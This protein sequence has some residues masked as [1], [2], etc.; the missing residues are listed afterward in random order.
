MSKI[1]AP[2]G[3]HDIFSPEIEKWQYLEDSIRRFFSCYLFT[4][5]RT[6]LF[7]HSELFLRG[8]GNE[9]EV[10]Q[11]EM[12]TFMDKGNRSITLR[13]E[14][15]ASVVRAILEHNL[16]EQIPLPRFFY[17][18][19]M[20]RYDKPQK[21]RYRQFHQ[22]GVE[23]FKEKDPFVDAELIDSSIRFLK[24]LNIDS[25]QLYVNSV[26][27]QHC[28]P[29][30]LKQLMQVAATFDSHLCNDCQRKITTNPLRIFDCKNPQCQATAN[31]FPLI[32]DHLCQD[33]HHHFNQLKHH[34]TEL[35]TSYVLNP[36]LVRGLDYY[37]KTAF[38]VVSTQLGSQDAILGG[39]RYDD[40]FTE[41]GGP[42]VPAI[43]FAAGMERILLHMQNPPDQQGNK[44]IC[45][46][47]YDQSCLAEAVKITSRIRVL[48][49]P[50]YIDYEAKNLKK[51]F[52]LSNKI[53][54]AFTIV[55]GEEEIKTNT[56]SIKNMIEQQQESINQKDLQ[57]WLTK[58]L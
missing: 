32:T 45:V 58:H 11:K 34:L 25:I 27:C 2:K 37:T 47:F 41:L 46:A 44:T 23:I 14:N 51:Q 49:Y 17:I 9:T 19:P 20:F 55:I 12:Y 57:S 6:P 28:R 1:I 5:I 42:G 36:K 43:G 13:P 40:L 48:G 30:Y 21:G 26:G 18:G 38:E 53:N 3:T 24:S 16:F 50:A 33:C 39:G 10:V 31:Q 56:L 29:D 8:I 7:E 22:F 52:K 15:T 4:E 54:A 35:G